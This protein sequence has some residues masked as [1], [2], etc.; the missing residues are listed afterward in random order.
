MLRRAENVGASLRRDLWGLLL[1]G[2]YKTYF[3]VGKKEVV[4]NGR[5]TREQFNARTNHSR[6]TPVPIARLGER[7]YWLFVDRWYW[8]N[9]NLTA[10]EV[11]ALLH[12]RESR[13]EDTLNRAKSFA[14]AGKRPAPNRRTG[15]P[16]DV[17][18]LVWA[19][20]GGTC[21]ECGSNTELQF[22]HVIP[23]ALGGGATEA[24]IQLLC[25]PCNRRKGASIV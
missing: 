20:D 14:A 8:E 18:Q 16:D 19:R 15:I 9:E 24:N 7:V 23:V 13:R 5:S 22:D 10:G 21:R 12:M 1:G 2:K 6:S 17:K 4:L 3:R 11:H 25:G